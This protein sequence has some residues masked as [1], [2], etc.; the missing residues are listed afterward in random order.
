M[1]KELRDLEKTLKEAFEKDMKE[2]AQKVNNALEKA[3][4][5][6]PQDLNFDS[7]ILFIKEKVSASTSGAFTV[8]ELLEYLPK[9]RAFLQTECCK[10]LGCSHLTTKLSFK[11]D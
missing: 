10:F 2:Q 3:M 1:K 5:S 6:S 7:I 4:G 8:S 11:Y 9:E